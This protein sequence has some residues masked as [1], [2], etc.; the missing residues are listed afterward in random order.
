[1]RP[2]VI[3]AAI[4]VATLA[5]V[6]RLLLFVDEYAV[7]LL[8][9]DQWTLWNALFQNA[10]LWTVW[11][12]QHGPQRQGVGGLV[13]VATAHLSDW[14][15]RAE[16]F[17]CA[18]IVLI[19]CG[20][21]LALVR[22]VRGRWVLTDIIVPLIF[23]TL[24][25]YELLVVTTNPAHGPLPLLLV[26]LFALALQIKG[27]RVRLATLV[28]V[29][30]LATQTGFA[31]FLG[32]IASVMF[33]AS[34]WDAVQRRSGILWHAGAFAGAVASLALFFFGLKFD[35][36]VACFQ[37]PDP[38]PARYMISAGVLFS[39]GAQPLAG[40]FIACAYVALA[41][42]S[43]W[44]TIARRKS[45]GADA[46]VFALLSFSLLFSFN[47]V[48]GRTCLGPSALS[49]PRYV[50][51]LIPALFGAYLALTSTF[52]CPWLR[53]GALAAVCLLCVV[54]EVH[55]RPH[56]AAFFAR[57]KR[58]FQNCYVNTGDAEECGRLVPLWVD[59]VATHMA[60]KLRYLRERHLSF[61]RPV[62]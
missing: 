3:T 21:A 13:T 47:A 51:Y 60:A 38:Q 50:P 42:R 32:L 33:A 61:F 37:F 58:T 28:S 14:N 4:A 12:W 18:A 17:V 8:F 22:I 35:P 34:L 45:N 6:V 2:S 29:T 11:R 53:R 55:F 54:K 1:M 9:S 62:R 39:T 16:A 40:L 59:P 15:L 43:A 48:I 57:H 10:D 41:A 31:W 44:Q 30:F 46:A 5:C 19:A 49:S 25:Q 20:G 23:L 52:S 56:S 7:D 27:Q 24:W 36:A 26:V